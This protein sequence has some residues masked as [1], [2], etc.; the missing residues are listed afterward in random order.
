LEGRG[1][2]SKGWSTEIF[3]VAIKKTLTFWKKNGLH[4]LVADQFLGYPKSISTISNFRWKL[5]SWND[6]PTGSRA[7]S[8]Q[9]RSKDSVLGKATSP[10]TGATQFWPS[11]IRTH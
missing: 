2:L 5:R 6:E 3:S 4:K 10:K 11:G 7:A 1:R 8:K 9:Q